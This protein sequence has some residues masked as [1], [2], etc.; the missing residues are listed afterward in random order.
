M[1]PHL[2]QSMSS[3]ATFGLVVALYLVF[4]GLLSLI[5]T[6]MC[7]FMARNDEKRSG[8]NR[9]SG[10]SA[11][12]M[13]LTNKAWWIVFAGITLILVA[14]VLPGA[15]DLR[16]LRVGFALAIVGLIAVMLLGF[17]WKKWAGAKTAGSLPNWNMFVKCYSGLNMFI[18]FST[19]LSLVVFL[20][21]LLLELTFNDSAKW[22]S[23]IEHPFK[24]GLMTLT[25]STIFLFANL[26]VFARSTDEIVP[27]SKPAEPEEE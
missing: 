24:I 26:S 5:I 9:L 11:I 21:I 20:F 17:L 18:L 8:V 12:I 1:S 16:S 7:F 6:A 25:S 15:T 22:E 4:F 13:T 2:I 3:I 19:V 23:A 27:F 10:K 14:F